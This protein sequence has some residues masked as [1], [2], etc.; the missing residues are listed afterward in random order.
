MQNQEIEHLPAVGGSSAK[1]VGQA[2]LETK[3]HP[4]NTRDFAGHEEIILPCLCG[5]HSS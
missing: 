1:P 5:R 2:D 3:T 4:T